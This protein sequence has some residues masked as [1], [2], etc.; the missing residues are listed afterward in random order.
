MHFKLFFCKLTLAEKCRLA[1]YEVKLTL[2]QFQCTSFFI[3]HNFMSLFVLLIQI[4]VVGRTNHF[5]LFF[6]LRFRFPINFQ[7]SPTYKHLRST[8][9]EWWC[10]WL[11]RQNI[12]SVSP[13]DS[14]H[15]IL[16]NKQTGRNFKNSR[17]EF[18]STIVISRLSVFNKTL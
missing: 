3:K 15:F 6:A 16:M 13:Y 5:S 7:Q 2:L 18:N 10:I 14:Q 17:D 1:R 8:R 11:I 4:P 12:Q 9:S